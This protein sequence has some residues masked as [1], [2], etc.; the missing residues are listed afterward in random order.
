M[1]KTWT[2][3]LFVLFGSCAY[4]QTSAL[5]VY[6]CAQN[7]IQAITSGLKS[8]NYLQGVIP[9]CTVSVFLTGTKTIAT[10]TPQTPFRAN[11]NG[12]ITPIYASTGVGYDVFFSGGISPN[13]YATP[14]TLT[15]VMVGGSGG[16]A[17]VSE[18]VPGTNTT[19]TPNVGGSCTGNVTV[20]STGSGGPYLPL[21]SLQYNNA[22]VFGGANGDYAETNFNSFTLGQIQKNSVS[23]YSCDGTNCTFQ[24]T[25]DYIAGEDVL[26]DY[27]FSDSCLN[28]TS[29][30]ALST[31]LSS[32]QFE[33]VE[34]NTNCTGV[35][36][37]SGGDASS[38]NTGLQVNSGLYGIDLN[39]V[40]DTAG[41]GGGNGISLCSTS[42]SAPTCGS[43]DASFWE[44]SMTAD[45]GI[46]M[47]SKDQVEIESAGGLKLQNSSDFSIP[48]SLVFFAGTTPPN[49]TFNEVQIAAPASA[50][51]YTMRLP[52]SQ[53]AGAL[54]NDGSGNLSW[55]GNTNVS[56]SGIASQIAYWTAPNVLS[57][58]SII[59]L[60]SGGT[61]ATTAAGALANLGAVSTAT[62]V[63][64]HALSS[65]VTVSASD[66]TT[67]TLPHAQLPALVSADIPANAA[68]TSGTAGALSNGNYLDTVLASSIAFPNGTANLAADLRLGNN[69][70]YGYIEVEVQGG[71]VYGYT[72]GKITKIFSLGMA[73]SNNIYSYASELTDDFGP[74][75]S[76]IVIGEVA[77]DATNSTYKI[78]I[79]H[80]T[81]NGNT[82]YVH[83]REF[84][85][86]GATTLSLSSV[87]TLTA[88]AQQTP[89]FNGNATTATSAAGLS[90]PLAHAIIFPDPNAGTVYTASQVIGTFYAPM[91]GTVPASGTGTY[92]GVAST[93]VCKLATAATA[94]TTFTFADGGTSFRHSGI[95]GLSGTTGTFTISS[96]KAI[97]IRRQESH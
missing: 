49:T 88:L 41:E 19:C 20:N 13:T 4:A 70:Y 8:S 24:A 31:G 26:L 1:R 97:A 71:A 2:S 40:A 3:L 89:Q 82:Y 9:Y 83:V 67:G 87:Y 92:N 29:S 66:L 68:N 69:S 77:W 44:I 60:T 84:I 57:G 58:I 95:C 17:G 59:P 39:T 72:M 47:F 65:N 78:P 64:G 55:A 25:N 61:G 37:G 53:G 45:N 35:I 7:G 50:D 93:S 54:T 28:G 6:Y 94:S 51:G 23:S 5:P 48:G 56:G 46:F 21:G 91:A 62:T 63:N 33:L 38:N 52:S 96:A 11:A 85:N 10:T 16:S 18:I 79:S 73:P 74:I 80:I 76:Q 15:D 42:A 27:N 43:G 14:V 75:A 30:P 22:G 36:S 12:S 34:S 32:S 90:I 81:S 86:T